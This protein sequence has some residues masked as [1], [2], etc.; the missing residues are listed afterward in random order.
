MCGEEWPYEMLCTQNALASN[1]MG[2]RGHPH[3][4]SCCVLGGHMCGHLQLAVARVQVLILAFQSFRFVYQILY[5]LLRRR[6]LRLHV[7]NIY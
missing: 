4:S 2:Q 6:D 7:E 5:L 3:P 1:A